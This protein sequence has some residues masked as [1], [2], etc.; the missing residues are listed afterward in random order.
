MYI[1]IATLT[2]FKHIVMQQISRILLAKLK[3]FTL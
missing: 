1:K 3:L 2:I